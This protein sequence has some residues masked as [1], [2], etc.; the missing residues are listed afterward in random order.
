MTDT[1]AIRSGS[2]RHS[3]LLLSEFL[4]HSGN[5]KYGAQDARWQNSDPD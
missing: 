5:R 3:G 1:D 2:N 4:S